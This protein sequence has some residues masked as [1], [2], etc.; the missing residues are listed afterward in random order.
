[1]LLIAHEV[2]SALKRCMLPS[3]TGTVLFTFR[4]L[5]QVNND[6]TRRAMLIR[7][8][9]YVSFYPWGSLRAD[10]N[11]RRSSL[12]HI[13]FNLW[14]ANPS[15]AGPSIFTAGGGVLWT[16]VTTV[17]GYIRTPDRLH[18]SSIREGEVCGWLVSRQPPLSQAGMTA[19]G[20]TSPLRVKVTQ[21]LVEAIQ[22]WE[23]SQDGQPPVVQVLYDCRFLVCFDIGNIPR[24]LVKQLIRNETDIFICPNTRWYWPKVMEER[25]EWANVLHSE[26]DQDDLKP[27]L[28]VGAISDYGPKMYWRPKDPPI[29][30]GWI[31]IQWVRAL[32]AH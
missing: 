30:S 32:S 10:A 18:V 24:P 20:I 27:P 11:R 26:I 15:V 21:Q 23:L 4:G 28:E 9:R 1:M 14:R 19:R 2:D 29:S 8:I 13:M 6:L 16:P 3:P 22:D 17:N 25:D 31:S 7:V 12:S 5:A